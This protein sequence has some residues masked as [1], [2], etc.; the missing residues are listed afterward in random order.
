MEKRMRDKGIEV[1]T[2]E[3]DR[4][5]ALPEGIIH[6][7][8]DRLTIL[9]VV[10]TSV[11]SKQWKSFFVSFPCLNIDQ[12]NFNRLSYHW[13]KNFVYLK[14]RSMS[15]NEERL[16]I[17]KFRLR[18]LY[19]YVSE[20]K[21][22]I[23]N[24][25]RL[26]SKTSTINEFDFEIM[27]A[28]VMASYF[29]WRELFH[30][31]YN[32]KTLVVLRLSG[33]TV[34]QPSNRD[35][36][37]SHLEILRLENIKVKKESVIDW[38]FTSCSLIREVKLVNCHGL[39]HLKVCGNVGHLKVLEIGFC[40]RLESVE[41]HAPSLEKLVL[42]EIK[43]SREYRFCMGLTID[44]E[45]CESLRE[46]TL[47]NSTIRG[48]TFTRIFSKCSN[49]ESLVLDRCMHFF[50]IRIASHKLRKLVLKICFDLLVTDI[51]APNL[52][53]F[54]FCN[55]LPPGYYA[56]SN[57]SST[58]KCPIQYCEKISQLQEC[59]L[60]FNQL[61]QSKIMWIS[62]WFNKFRDSAG[63]KMVTI[64][65]KNK[66]P[67]DVVV[68]EDL[69]LMA[70]LSLMADVSEGA[71]RTIITTMSFVD[72]ADYVFGDCGNLLEKVLVISSTDKSLL[73]EA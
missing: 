31:I 44:S 5:S 56:D 25:T 30:H 47:C 19:G 1:S 18:M 66:R 48:L 3:K 37:F 59:M 65:P 21:E 36:K 57:H 64:Y 41:I 28:S 50:K 11:L 70:E 58:S 33:L 7:I 20:A 8:L 13:F 26:V 35:I 23:E 69:G 29:Y 52:T 32:A 54:T 67:Y 10:R 4:I 51:E 22:E 53:S 62:L 2:N 39:E 14:V 68:F 71:R 46:L 60:D 24:C 72:L 73:Y 38:F 42:S 15:I 43:R 40:P 12:Q 61:L 63:Q 9:D 27:D 17:N 6:E 16:V 45:T 49:V 34:M 55:Y